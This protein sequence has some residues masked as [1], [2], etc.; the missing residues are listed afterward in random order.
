MNAIKKMRVAF[1]MIELVFVIVIL[2]IISS[3]GA[4]VIAQVY[5]SYIV[6]RAQYRASAKTQIA[7]NQIDHLL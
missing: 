6:Q 7:L 1:S 2:G 3:I 4:E 5:E